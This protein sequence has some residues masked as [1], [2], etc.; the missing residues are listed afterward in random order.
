MQHSIFLDWFGVLADSDVMARGWG[1]IEAKMLKEKFGGSLSRW[2]KAND[3]SLRWIIRFW[4]GYGPES[5]SDYRRVL[6]RSIVEGMRRTF[7]AGGVTPPASENLLYQL[8]RELTNEI[9]RRVNA[10]Y[11]EVRAVLRT[12]K[13]TRSRLFL[14]SGADSNYVN[15]LL[16][17]SG[18]KTFFDGVFSPEKMCAFKGSFRYWKSVL[19]ASQAIPE[20]SF[21][22]DDNPKFLAIPTRLGLAPVL[23]ARQSRRSSKHTT[24]RTLRGLP[25]LVERTI[26]RSREKIGH[27][28]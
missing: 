9:A 15:A 4:S 1:R 24:I 23:V 2:R 8:D 25:E 18:L 26:L 7:L 6:R 10:L 27:S 17:G 21:V 20:F 3:D 28:V 16:D 5:R 11:P 12:L 14:T 19:R 22:V 13:Q